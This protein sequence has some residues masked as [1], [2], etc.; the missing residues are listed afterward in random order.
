VTVPVNS[1][2]MRSINGNP[3]WNQKNYFEQER[4]QEILSCEVLIN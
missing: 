3:K 2:Y 4:G 1:V